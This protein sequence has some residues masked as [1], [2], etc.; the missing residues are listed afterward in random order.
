MRSRTLWGLLLLAVLVSGCAA[1]AER[2]VLYQASTINALLEG[3][4]DGTI[5]LGELQKH[6]DF[7]IGTFDGLDGEMILLDGCFYQVRGDGKVYRPGP[8]AT[9]PL[10]TV[11]FFVADHALAADG[12]FDLSD[13]ESLLDRTTPE[14]N[15][16]VAIRITGTFKRVKTRSVPKQE[17]PYPRLIDVTAKQPTFEFHD[18][19]GT[20][21]GFRFPAYMKGI[22]VPGYH[23]HFLT[24]DRS[25][26][27]HVLEIETEAMRIEMD[28]KREVFIALPRT[29][30]F[31]RAD[32]SKDKEAEVRKAEQ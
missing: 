4:Y 18:V 2:D 11:A 10:A 24:A 7:G 19:K 31:N 17:K 29:E 28:V 14:R 21:V 26:G 25:G 13:L 16:P 20:L 22:G 9:T 27:G 12:P 23:L 8:G 6:G 1:Q 3:V 15:V 32:L 30:M 5:T